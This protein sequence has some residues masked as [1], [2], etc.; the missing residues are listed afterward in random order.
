MKAV[1]RGETPAP[2]HAAMPSFDSVE[3]LLRLLTPQ[4]RALLALIRDRRPQ[5]ITELSELSGRAQPNLLRTLS[6]LEAVG[7]I[8][9][10]NV[11]RC[12]VPTTSVR[13]FRIKVDPFS[14]DDRVEWS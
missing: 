4:N 9:I 13:P 8:Q 6:K 7:F 11:K 12:K 3:A 1:A 2:T 5:S 10:K 14:Q